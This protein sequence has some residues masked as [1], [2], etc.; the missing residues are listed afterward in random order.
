AGLMAVVLHG[1]TSLWGQPLLAAEI[2]ASNNP[3]SKRATQYLALQLERHGDRAGAL[4]VLQRHL[5]MHPES[6]GLALQVLALSCVLEPDRSHDEEAKRVETSLATSMAE[7][8]VYE[9][10]QGLYRMAVGEQCD[11][12]TR[13]AIY[14]VAS[15]A[16]SNP[17]FAAS[18]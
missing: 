8:G 11:T 13:D 17:S 9:A 12:L 1:T 14:S 10:L 6:A 16:V 2:W 18:R 5:E 15:T 7:Y 3:E 4:R